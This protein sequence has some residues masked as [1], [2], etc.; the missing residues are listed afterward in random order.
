[1]NKFKHVGST[2]LKTKKTIIDY[3]TTLETASTTDIYT[4]RKTIKQRNENYNLVVGILDNEAL[5][6]AFN[7]MNLEGENITI[8]TGD[9]VIPVIH[10]S[11]NALIGEAYDRPFEFR[12]Y[13]TN[14]S[15]I[16]T[17]EEE[18]KLQLDNKLKILVKN[19]AV[20]GEA[21]KLA[22][23]KLKYWATYT[24]QDV[25]ERTANHKLK[26]LVLD[27]DLIKVFKDGFKDVIAVNEEQYHIGLYNGNVTIEKIEP[28]ELDVYQLG[29]SNKIEDAGILVWT[30][31]R[32]ANKILE[33]YYDKLTKSDI[34]YLMGDKTSSDN[35]LDNSSIKS[36]PMAAVDEQEIA[37]LSVDIENNTINSDDNV[38]HRA[39]GTFRVRT[40]YFRTT[41][42][43]KEV[44]G[45]NEKTGIEETRLEDEAYTITTKEKSVNRYINEWY[46]ATSISK[47]IWI[48]V[49]PCPVQATDLNNLSMNKPPIV[50]TIYSYGS[51]IGKS[52]VDILKPIQYEWTIFS[53]KLSLLWARNWG[54][55]VKIDVSRIPK[56]FSL[57]LFMNWITSYGIIVE[58]PFEEGNRGVAAG[59]MRESVGA[60][61][62]GLGNEIQAALGHLMYLKELADETVGI[63]RQRRG[64]LMASDGLGTTQ[65]AI[66][67]SNKMTEELFQEHDAVRRR[68][69]ELALE[70]IKLALR[71]KTDK[72]AQYILDDMATVIYD[73]EGAGFTETSFG[74]RLTNSTKRLQLE[75]IFQQLS[76]AAMQNGT[77]T[78]SQIMELY[79]TDSMREKINLLKTK[80][81]E[82]RIQKQEA[83]K[84][85]Q[86]MQQKMQEAQLKDNEAA[87]QIK[88]EEAK[89]KAEATIEVARI[90][91]EARITDASI[92]ANISEN[93]EVNNSMQ[94]AQVN[95]QRQQEHADNLAI[96]QQKLAK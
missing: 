53:K 75:A 2:K 47:D 68:V 96:K 80:E 12:A 37:Y 34:E 22:L 33:M 7:P 5:K 86:E 52:I 39:D 90:N 49:Q 63:T 27:Q 42:L 89:I 45:L 36:A 16:S 83:E 4:K 23:N 61:D 54:K 88:L 79:T 9:E 70:Y 40:V 46:E 66:T 18:L 31:Y 74:I 67:R 65:E 57:D 91:A 72:K 64:E 60:V 51:R 28:N 10:P 14:P 81:E 17:K 87:R 78:I 20:Q 58:N 1:M 56:E 35:I 11:I 77:I 73:T 59:S 32:S 24:F 69:L 3:V 95:M 38:S 71:N 19:S 41:R 29:Q 55:L 44:T 50:G 43:V 13:L 93:K 85:Q 48:N 21:L 30:R 8:P 84:R 92:G 15:D 6:K 76:H 94:Q 62:V 82:I 26:D 25:R